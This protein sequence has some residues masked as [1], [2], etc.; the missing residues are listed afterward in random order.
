M[1]TKAFDDILFPA[2]PVGDAPRIINRLRTL[3]PATPRALTFGLM[4]D[5][6]WGDP[7]FVFI[8]L[9]IVLQWNNA[10]NTSADASFA[11]AVLIGQL[12]V[13]LGPTKEDATITVVKLIVDILGFWDLE[14][15]KYGFLARLRDSK[16][17]SIDITGGLGVWGEYGDQSRY[18]LAAGGFNPRFKDVPAEVASA[19]DRLGASFKVGRFELKLVGYFA[20]TP[21][22]IQ[23]GLDFTASAKL[24]PVG[25]KGEL[26]FD[27]L[28]YREPS[29]HFIADFRINAEVTYKGHTLASVKVT[30]TLEGP[31]LWHVYGKVTF[32]I[33]WWDISKSFD[34]SWGDAPAISTI[35]TDVQV[36]LAA[37]LPRVENWSAQMPTGAAML[38]TLAAEPGASAATRAHPLGRFLFSQRVVP[39]GLVLEKFGDTG[40]AGANRFD[41]GP[42][43]VGG[44]SLTNVDPVTE[45][46][47]RSKFRVMSEDSRLASPSFEAMQAGVAFSSDAFDVGGGGLATDLD[48]ETAY[49]DLDPRRFNHT[50]RTTLVAILDHAFVGT[51]ALGGAAARSSLRADDRIAARSGAQVAIVP[52][53]LAAAD[54]TAFT[55]GPVLTGQARTVEMIA[56][57]QLSRGRGARLV[58]AFELETA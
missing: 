21:C 29:T 47:P 58:E 28:I 15:K 41:L 11:R 49:L 17:A 53:P 42:V 26:G 13:E 38:V 51:L 24:G 55:G 5:I 18:L 16:L 32:S 27:V 4:F 37:E 52:S 6:G 45:S 14:Q 9:G 7:R 22:T 3:F 19:M 40:V 31:G 46:F 35:S 30:G 39:L 54:E 44:V 10:F 23:A 33:L 2:D 25:L 43:T 56:E 1:R 57:Q 8:R 36:L 12:R 48:Y 50:R 20:L 34:E